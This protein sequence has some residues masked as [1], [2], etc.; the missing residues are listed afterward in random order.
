[1]KWIKLQAKKIVGAF[2]LVLAGILSLIV[3]AC[4]FLTV[5]FGVCYMFLDEVARVLLKN[6]DET[7]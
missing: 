7:S 3:S 6:E 2:C 1:M 4:V 5:F